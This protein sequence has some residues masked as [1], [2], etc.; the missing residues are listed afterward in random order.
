MFERIAE[1]IMVNVLISGL[2]F[3]LFILGNNTA[4]YTVDMYAI[5]CLLLFAWSFC[6]YGVTKSC[7]DGYKIDNKLRKLYENYNK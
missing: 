4:E 7:I 2:F 3:G 1:W 6:T 5:N